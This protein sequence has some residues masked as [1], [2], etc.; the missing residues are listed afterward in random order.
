MVKDFV[1][2]RTKLWYIRAA[3]A[4]VSLSPG[5]LAPHPSPSPRARLRLAFRPIVLVLAGI[6]RKTEDE[7]EEAA[8]ESRRQ[9]RGRRD[10]REGGARC[11]ASARPPPLLLPLPLLPPLP[12][13][14]LEAARSGRCAP[15]RTSTPPPCKACTRRRWARA[16]ACSSR[17]RCTVSISSPKTGEKRRRGP[18]SRTETCC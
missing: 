5:S 9:N 10:G 15:R 16:R 6:A 4:P 1:V 18:V 14:V 2:K 3:P 11:A 8:C 13:P 12:R 7:A 17:G